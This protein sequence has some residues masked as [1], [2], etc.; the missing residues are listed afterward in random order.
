MLKRTITA[1]CAMIIF[2]PVCYFSGTVIFPVAMAIASLIAAYEMT[3]CTGVRKNLSVSIPSCIFG[4]LL[5]L[6]PWFT[7]GDTIKYA[8]SCFI[9]YLIVLFT[10]LVFSK[11][12]L[13][14]TLVASC[15]MGVLYASMSFMCIV[16]LREAGAYLYL[17]VF[18]GPWVSDIFAY[19]CGRLFGKHKLIPQV[20]PKKTVEGSVGGIIFTAIA[21]VVYG[22]I[23]K[24]Y[25]NAS[26]VANPIAMALA[27]AVTSVIAQIGDLTASAIKRRFDIKD[28][29]RIFPGH[30]G[31]MDR[32]DSVLL[33]APVLYIISTIPYVAE[34]ML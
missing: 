4:A 5:P 12:K 3:G 34:K 14:Y 32:F 25:F 8:F 13:D 18:V 7:E 6:I 31:V 17:L 16:L 11:G 9:I 19:L 24:T 27:G 23:I 21:F 1:V 10:T 29:G 30:G 2:I 33:T 22:I 26:A 20:S 28:Y 15:F